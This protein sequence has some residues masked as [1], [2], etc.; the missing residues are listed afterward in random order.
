[1]LYKRDTK[2]DAYASCTCIYIS[3]NNNKKGLSMGTTIFDPV[4]LNLVF[5]LFSENFNV[6]YNF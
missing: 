3:L 1:M 5:A 2:G 6:A 4:T